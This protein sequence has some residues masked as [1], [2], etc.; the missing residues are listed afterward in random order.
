MKC[1]I[2]NK[3]SHS[4]DDTPTLRKLASL[5]KE[6]MDFHNNIVSNK[7]DCVLIDHMQEDNILAANVYGDFVTNFDDRIE[8][9]DFSIDFEFEDHYLKACYITDNECL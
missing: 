3:S 7:F 1:R 6:F 8:F 4:V 9:S 2:Y 5:V